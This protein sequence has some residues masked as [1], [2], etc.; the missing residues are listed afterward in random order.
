MQVYLVDT[1][2]SFKA[3]FIGGNMKYTPI[4]LDMDKNFY[5]ISFILVGENKVKV[6]IDRPD[7]PQI[8]IPV[9][10]KLSELASLVDLLKKDSSELAKSDIEENND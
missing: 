5:E 2:L 3:F 9:I 10:I 1:S 7:D 8:Y 4:N 6:E